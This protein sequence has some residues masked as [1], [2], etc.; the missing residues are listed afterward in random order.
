MQYLSKD[1]HSRIA[2]EKKRLVPAQLYHWHKR[3]WHL[4]SQ[5]FSLPKNKEMKNQYNNIGHRETC[6]KQILA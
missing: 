2:S 6:V 4:T 1:K 5:L 3:Q